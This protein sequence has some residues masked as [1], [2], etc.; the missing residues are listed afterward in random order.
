MN[1]VKKPLDWFHADPSN[2]R[3]SFDVEELRLLNAT[4]RIRQ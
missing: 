4:L 2:P 1:V 3:K